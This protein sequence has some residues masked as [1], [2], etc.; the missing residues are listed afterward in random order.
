MNKRS[1]YLFHSFSL[2]ELKKCFLGAAHQRLLLGLKQ[3][4]EGWSSVIAFPYMAL[5]LWSSFSNK[6]KILWLNLSLGSTYPALP[7]WLRENKNKL[8]KIPP[9]RQTL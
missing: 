5:V 1:T 3:C 6:S 7:Y 9:C 2:L 4:W 8:K